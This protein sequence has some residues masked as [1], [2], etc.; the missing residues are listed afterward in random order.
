MPQKTTSRQRRLAP[1]RNA[2]REFSRMAEY[3]I[4]RILR[5]RKACPIEDLAAGLAQ[6]P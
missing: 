5:E 4:I 6:L 1:A 2:A 3:G